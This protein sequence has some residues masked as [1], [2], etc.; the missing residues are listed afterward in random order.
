M[1]V[2]EDSHKDLQ[3]GNI[4]YHSHSDP[5]IAVCK[6]ILGVAMVTWR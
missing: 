2:P 5:I 3:G 4:H 6:E 1:Q